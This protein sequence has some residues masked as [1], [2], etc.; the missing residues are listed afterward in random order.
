MRVVQARA[1]ETSNALNSC[2]VEYA[3]LF[4]YHVLEGA[5][6]VDRNYNRK[7][8]WRDVVETYASALFMHGLVQD[9]LGHNS[10]ELMEQQIEANVQQHT[11]PEVKAAAVDLTKSKEAAA[12][13]TTPTTQAQAPEPPVQVTTQGHM[14]ACYR[15][16]CAQPVTEFGPNAGNRSVQMR[17]RA[18]AAC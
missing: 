14:T 13:T 3:T 4:A 16:A 7:K 10:V 1:T 5:L 12:E 17:F 6:D 18:I 2:P 11:P 8:Y 15:V 9:A